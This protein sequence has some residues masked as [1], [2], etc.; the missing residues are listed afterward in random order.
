MSVRALVKQADLTRAFKAA[1][2]GGFESV[3]VIARIDGSIEIIAGNAAND[4][5]EVELE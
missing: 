4:S 5:E 2:D 3:R 1:R